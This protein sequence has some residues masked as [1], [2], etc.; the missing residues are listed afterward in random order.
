MFTQ[1]AADGCFKRTA[2]RL[3]VG[4]SS[5]TASDVNSHSAEAVTFASSVSPLSEN[6]TVSGV[7]ADRAAVK[8]EHLTTASNRAPAGVPVDRA[9]GRL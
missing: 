5:V 1:P 6:V 9:S 3:K 4:A 2:S 8:Q 7:A